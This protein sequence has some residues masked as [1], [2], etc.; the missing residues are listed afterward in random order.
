MSPLPGTRLGPYEIQGLIG[1]GGMGEVYKAKDPKLGREVAIKVLPAAFAEDTDHLRRF[2]QEARAAGALN[3]PNITVIHDL[4]SHEGAPYLVMELLEGESLRAAMDAGPMASARAAELGEQ[5]AA[6]L[7]AAHERGIVHRDLK[8]ENL[9]LTRDGVV[10]I[11]DFG[12]AKRSRIEGEAATE[13]MANLTASGVVMGTLHYMSPEQANG[14]SVD[15]HTDQFSLGIVLYELLSGRKPFGGDS[16][17]ETLAAIVR[18]DP[19]PLES[20]SLGI[21]AGLAAIVQRCLAKEPKERY[22]ST[23]DLANHLSIAVR[24]AHSGGTAATGFQPVKAGARKVSTP[25]WA[26]AASL[27]LALFAGAFLWRPWEQ[28]PMTGRIPSV[29]ALPARV[30]GA[31][32]SAFL[33][34]AIPDT[35]STLLA[36]VEG[37]DTKLPPSSFQVEKLQGDIAKIA[38]AYRVENLVLSTVTVQGENLVLNVKLADAATQKVRWASQFEGTRSTYHQLARH[39]AEALIQALKPGAVATLKGPTR[40]SE[41]ELAIQEGK[42]FS[43]RF[44]FAEAQAALDRALKLEPNNA[45]AH[46]L[47]ADSH[48]AK[49]D[50]EAGKASALRA[51]DL[52]SRCGLAWGVLSQLEE[53]GSEG[54]TMDLNRVMERAVKGVCLA[55]GDPRTH[56]LLACVAPGTVTLS[57]AAANRSMELDPLLPGC[58]LQVA[59]GLGL[60][61][62]AGEGLPILERGLRLEP[63]NGDLLEV[64]RILLCKLGRWQEAEAAFK[65]PPGYPDF[66]FL[67]AK[68][69]LDDARSGLARVVAA[70]RKAT[71]MSAQKRNAHAIFH[72]PIC[73]R[74]G[75]TEDA[76]FLLEKAIAS[77]CPPQV[78]WILGNPDLQRLRGD[79]RYDHVLQGAR[80][81]ASVV[82]YQLERAKARGELPR[83]LDQPLAELKALLGPGAQ[84]EA[85]R[86]TGP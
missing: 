83:Y 35:L 63:G 15:F 2:E 11:L 4:G 30:L 80:K 26:L 61:G 77:G 23:R 5:I 34:D 64:K 21:P 53:Y 84:L 27:L 74:L 24:H 51:L 76:F 62:R 43:Q 12:L 75:M 56:Q 78:D 40:N 18:D 17:A 69:D 48:L 71:N 14:R 16:M 45:M 19:A 49:G 9:F 59:L 66:G 42:Y 82:A 72:A 73:A 68:G 38:E 39:A 8:P 47:L 20:L 86:G 46:A 10:K 29:L 41:L 13:A 81:G 60:L 37:L 57:I 70:D 85:P 44:R 32:E 25:R 36:G 50:R 6:G 67:V 52:D 28:S 3:H 79:S 7:A 54:P 58:H 22:A 31:P 55:P 1:A 65:Y 33:T